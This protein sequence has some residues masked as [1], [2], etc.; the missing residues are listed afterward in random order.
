MPA[1]KSTNKSRRKDSLYIGYRV[2]VKAEERQ[3]YFTNARKYIARRE[4]IACLGPPMPFYCPSPSGGDGIWLTIILLIG[5]IGIF[6]IAKRI[7]RWISVIW[8]GFRTNIDQI[9]MNKFLIK[10]G[11]GEPQTQSKC[12]I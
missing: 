2:E 7:W 3:T 4:F 12:I 8:R 5:S 9:L 11:F 1:N 6:F 10:I